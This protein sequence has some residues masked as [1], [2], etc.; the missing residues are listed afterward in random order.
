MRGPGQIA[1]LAALARPRVGVVTNVGTAHLGL[2]GSREAIGAA[3]GELLAALPDDGAGGRARRRAAARVVAARRACACARSATTPRPTPRCSPASRVPGGQR[4]RLRVGADEADLELALEG[5]HQALNVLAALTVAVELGVPAGGRARR[6]GGHP[7]AAVARRRAGAARRRRRHQRRLQREPRVAR[8]RPGGARRAARGRPAHRRAG[9]DGGARRRPHRRCTRRAGRRRPRA[10]STSWSPSVRRLRPTWR[11]PGRRSRPTG[12][13]TRRPPWRCWRRSC[14][15]ATRCWS[16][17][18][19][20]SA[21]R[22]WRQGWRGV[23]RIESLRDQCPRR[24][25]PRDRHLD[26]PGAALHRAAA[27]LPH[28]PEH[29][30]GG[31]GGAQ[32][33]AGHPDDGRHH[34][35]RRDGHPVPDPVRLR[36]AQPGGAGRDARLRGDRPARRLAQRHPPPLAGPARALQAARPAAGLDP[37]L[38]RRRTTRASRRRSSC[39]SST[40]TSTSGPSGTCSS[41]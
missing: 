28:R 31:A 41:S 29:P 33:Q 38:R 24:R 26:R 7:P 2:L 30:R 22:A 4:L 12:W 14:A 25:R 10:A 9:P 39:R 32:D 36:A 23:W 1:A 40:C 17:A 3:K 13:P 27:A 35:R 8:R 15:R 6:R 21:W 19:A 11:A 18:A 5:R 20:R 34:D 16:R 37:A